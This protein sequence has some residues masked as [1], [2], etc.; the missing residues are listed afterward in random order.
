MVTI[1][2]SLLGAFLHSVGEVW[3]AT[4]WFF[5][6]L[7]FGF[8]AWDGWLL[9]SHIQWLKGITWVLLEIKVPKNNL[10][11]PKA[12]EQIFAAAHT[13]YSYGLRWQDKLFKGAGEYFMAFE[14]VG[15]A[16]ET[17]FYLRTPARFRNMMESAIFA[18]FPEAEIVDADDYVREMPKAL[19]NEEFDLAG[20]E[21]VFRKP[22]FYPL[23]TYPEF[24]E[25]ANDEEE[26][27]DPIAPLIE[28]MEKMRG[29]QQ[30]W[31]Q[32]VVTPE[33]EDFVK[34]GEKEINKI[35][36][37]DDTPAAKPSLWP[38]LDLGITLS[39]AIRA[40]IE[41]PGPAN[42]AK[43]AN[44][45]KPKKQRVAALTASERE[46][47]EGIARKINK[48]ALRTTLRVVAIERKGET[49]N[50]LMSNLFLTL[51]YLR[52]FNTQNLQATRPDGG[53]RT[54]SIYG[55]FKT[56]KQKY[57]KRILFERYQYLAQNNSAPIM[58]IEELATMY[59]FPITA[60][61]STGLEKIESK[62]GAPP[63]TLPTIEDIDL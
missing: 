47:T 21:A 42:P 45:D 19:P 30:L 9:Y 29:D 49:A 51:S 24:L 3:S 7:I 5:L 62:K 14:L 12:M 50:G 4:W 48:L 38:T 37:I 46:R 35:H 54:F 27:V 36:Q 43:D 16:G 22:N 59:H 31:I 13:P 58:N 63:A 18:Q 25:N 32:F 26:R 61:S 41:H 28:A 6:P 55:T 33:G 52:Q 57:R 39:E 17:H 8:I 15:R 44:A 56:I 53:T 23:R 34:E 11:T 40:P 10:K 20:Y 1:F 60:V 2:L